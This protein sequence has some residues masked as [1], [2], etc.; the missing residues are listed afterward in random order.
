MNKSTRRQFLRYVSLS[1]I[2]S[3]LPFKAMAE[4]IGQV[5]PMSSFSGKS[6][7]EEV[8]AGLDLTGKTIVV[9][10]ANSG[11][12]LETMR[13]LAMRGAHVI[14]TGR[15]MEKAQKACDSVEGKCTPAVLELGDLQSVKACAESIIEMGKPIDVLICNAGIMAL[16]ENQQINGIEKQFYVNHIGHFLFTNML[17]EQVRAA[18]EGRV[19]ILSSSGHDSAPESGI[20][21]DNLSGE[22]DYSPF[23]QYGQSKLANALFSKEL[24]R[25]QKGVLTSNSIHPGVINTNLGRHM[26]GFMKSVLDKIGWLFM[27]S[28]EEGTATQVYV[29]TN[30]ALKGVTGYYFAD[31]NPAETN[32]LVDDQTLAKRLWDVSQEIVDRDLA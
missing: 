20:E 4:L 27:K 26:E 1:S 3:L 32:P 28:V 14:G 2:A 9:T 17:I 24:A 13:V 22:R 18:P 11:L 29:A 10:G 7:A 30:P 16:P 25:R 6:T 21:F 31:C 12:G 8:T 5:A 15:T 19:V 23:K